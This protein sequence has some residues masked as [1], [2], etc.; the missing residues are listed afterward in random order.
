MLT[1][2]QHQLLTFLIEHQAEHDISPSFDEMRRAVGWPV[3]QV[4]IG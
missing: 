3:N 1:E 2:K 4:F